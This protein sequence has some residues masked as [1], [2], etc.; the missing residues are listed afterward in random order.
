MTDYSEIRRLARGRKIALVDL[1]ARIGMWRNYFHD[2]EKN[3]RDIPWDK[4]C[5]IAEMMN[6][7]PERLVK[8]D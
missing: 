7:D 5:A 3:G 1:S 2:M 6:V 8:F 4:L